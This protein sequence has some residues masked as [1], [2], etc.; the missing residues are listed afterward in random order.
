MAKR[1]LEIDEPEMEGIMKASREVRTR[2]DDQLLVYVKT[3]LETTRLHYEADH[4]I[5]ALVETPGFPP[6]VMYQA[7]TPKVYLV[8]TVRRAEEA[9]T[10]LVHIAAGDSQANSQKCRYWV[11]ESRILDFVVHGF[12]PRNVVVMQMLAVR[13][14]DSWDNV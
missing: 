12:I 8:F 7:K 13:R 1:A 14:A 5:I 2:Y 9:G 6:F 11:D 4:I 3:W 10:Y